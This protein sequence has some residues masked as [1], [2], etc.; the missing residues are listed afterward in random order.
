[1]QRR[2]DGDKERTNLDAR[3]GKSLRSKHFD[4]FPTRRRPPGFHLRNEERLNFGEI[5]VHA[6]ELKFSK[7]FLIQTVG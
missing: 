7:I 3:R 2:C 6:R 1:M 4:A 5:K